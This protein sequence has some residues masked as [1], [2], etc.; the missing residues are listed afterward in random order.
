MRFWN[1]STLARTL[2]D[3]K[4]GVIIPKCCGRNIIQMPSV[5]LELAVAGKSHPGSC[6]GLQVN[7]LLLSSIGFCFVL[8]CFVL[9]G[10]E[11]THTHTHT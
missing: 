10:R 1:Q 3:G 7:S 2:S 5:K 11:N 8:F 9:F 4:W 6:S